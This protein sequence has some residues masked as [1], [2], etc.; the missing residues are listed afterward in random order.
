MPKSSAFDQE[1][2][3]PLK[4]LFSG[5]MKYEEIA[6]CQAVLTYEEIAS[7]DRFD[8]ICDKIASQVTMYPEFV[9]LLQR[10]ADTKDT[11]TI[12]MTCGIARVWGKVFKKEGLMGSVKVIGSGWISNGYVVTAAVKAELVS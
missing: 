3:C 1:L 4:T 11:K 8:T 10:I 7:D 5:T 9:S 2:E 6:F 12:V